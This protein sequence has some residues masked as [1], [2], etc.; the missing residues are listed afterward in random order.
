V[1]ALAT[2]WV[3]FSAVGIVGA[4]VQMGAFALLFTGLHVNYMVA[5][6]LA[7][8]TAV[9]HNFVWHERYTWKDR[10]RGDLRE[11]MYRLGRFH[12]GNGIVSIL[13]NLA[14]MRLLVGALDLNQYL[15]SGAS[16]AI[17]SLLNFAISEYFVFRSA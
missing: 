8:E 4:G 12:A 17:C 11:L 2:R 14:L 3:K 10:R 16:I 15:A 9:L 13:G 1:T 5:A 7:V 6:A